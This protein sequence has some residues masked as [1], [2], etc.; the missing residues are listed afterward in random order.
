MFFAT[1]RILAGKHARLPNSMIITDKINF[2]TS[3]QPYTSGSFADIRL[4]RYKGC[5]IAVKSLRV[6]TTDNFE[7]IRKVRRFSCRGGMVLR[8]SP[9]ILQRG[10][11]L[12]FTIPSEHPKACQHSGQHRPVSVCHGFGVDGTQ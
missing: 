10:Y 2:S 3:S 9:A 7:K 4:G 6:A 11:P 12:E 1:L 5:T 8:L